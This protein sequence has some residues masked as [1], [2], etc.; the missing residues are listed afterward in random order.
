MKTECQ[1]VI[2]FR[3]GKYFQNL[4]DDYGGPMSTAKKFTCRQQAE[5]FMRQ[6]EWI[7]FNGGMT[8][9]VKAK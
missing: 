8:I 9:P 3:S 7:L 2:E 4:E 6:H 5:D 1:F